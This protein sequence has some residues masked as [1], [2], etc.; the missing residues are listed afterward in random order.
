MILLLIICTY[1]SKFKGRCT[2]LV[3]DIDDVLNKY[4]ESRGGASLTFNSIR[5][6]RYV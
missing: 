5:M 4:S 6:K 3:D 1:P 2:F